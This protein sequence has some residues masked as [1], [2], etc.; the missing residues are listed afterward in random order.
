MPKPWNEEVYYIQG[1]YSSYGGFFSWG[2]TVAEALENAW[3]EGAS[4]GC[5]YRLLKIK[6]E[7]TVSHIDGGITYDSKDGW[8]KPLTGERPWP[9]NRRKEAAA[10]EK[11][12][13]AQGTA[14]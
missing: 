13:A 12:L 1:C 9:S 10:L 7:F 8:V 5:K 2:N 6:G 11:L 3:K 4:S 14:E